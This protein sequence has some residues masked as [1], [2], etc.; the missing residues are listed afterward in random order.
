MLKTSK[1]KKKQTKQKDK[2]FSS[3]AIYLSIDEIIVCYILLSIIAI[4]NLQC[5]YVSIH[6]VAFVKL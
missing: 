6:K 4:E 5:E 2:K 3:N 1:D